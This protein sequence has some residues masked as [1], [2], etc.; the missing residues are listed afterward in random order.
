MDVNMKG[1]FFDESTAPDVSHQFVF[2]YNVPSGLGQLLDNLESART[3]RDRP[4]V[5][6]QLT[7]VAVDFPR[8]RLVDVLR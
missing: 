7:P 8:S 2:C 5:G 6:P 4:T 3:D 1:V